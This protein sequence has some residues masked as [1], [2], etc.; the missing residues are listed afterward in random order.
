MGVVSR[1]RLFLNHVADYDWLIAVEFGRVEDGQPPDCWRGVEDRF[2]YLLDRPGGDEVGFKVLEFAEFD[3]E[4][5]PDV[6]EDLVGDDAPR[7]DV[8]VLTLTDVTAGEIIP[9]AREFFDGE[10]SVN[11]DFFDRAL[12]AG[13]REL[14]E[15]AL[16]W[17]R[18]CLQAG[19]SMAVFAIGYTLYDLERF[20][21]ALPHLR[22]YVEISPHGA[23]NWCWLGKGEQAVGNLGRARRAYER[24]MELSRAGEEETDAS[25][26]L[27]ELKETAR[28]EE[29]A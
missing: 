21:E 23:W 25:E 24:A 28:Q 6:E 12:E 15:Q 14:Y 10:S 2:A 19:D 11:R 7:F 13:G 3:P 29:E 1:P 20:E 22:R 27:A 8:P 5:D 17:W 18:C 4:E 26:L 16:F 9:A